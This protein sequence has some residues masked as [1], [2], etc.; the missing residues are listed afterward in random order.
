MCDHRYTYVY[1]YVNSTTYNT[2][3]IEYSAFIFTYVGYAMFLF[4]YT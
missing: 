2:Y 4:L 3:T 1:M